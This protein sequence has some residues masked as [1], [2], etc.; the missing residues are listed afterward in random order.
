MKLCLTNLTVVL[1]GIYFL[2]I[3]TNKKITI[4]KF[5]KKKGRFEKTTFVFTLKFAKH[6]HLT[7][8]RYRFNIFA[9]VLKSRNYGKQ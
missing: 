7:S 6:L 8:K 9:A 2:K 5:V 1:S 3:K 4:K